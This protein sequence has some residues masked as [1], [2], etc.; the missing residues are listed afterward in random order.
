MAH[1]AW[2][3]GGFASFL[4]AED[5]RVELLSSMP[6]A[7]GS[8]PEGSLSSG[9]RVRVKVARCRRRDA[10]EEPPMFVIEGRLIDASRSARDEMASLAASGGASPAEEAAPPSR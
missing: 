9:T 2:V 4:K 3:K 10:S 7:P 6:S 5:D 1:V 8:R